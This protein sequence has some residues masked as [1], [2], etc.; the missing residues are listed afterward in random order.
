[1][2]LLRSKSMS[3]LLARIKSSTC[4][5][6]I[7]YSAIFFSFS[8]CEIFTS[9]VDDFRFMISDFKL[10]VYDFRFTV[11]NRS[12]ISCLLLAIIY[13]LS[14]IVLIALLPVITC[15]LPSLSVY[16]LLPIR[17]LLPAYH[18]CTVCLFPA[19]SG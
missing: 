4:H 8:C 11:Y 14:V 3:H 18:L 7:R 6:Y 16:C 9:G 15:L 12:F 5:I 19:R 17:Y 1:M 10:T 2:I 13:L